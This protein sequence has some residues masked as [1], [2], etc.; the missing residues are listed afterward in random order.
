MKIAFMIGNGFDLN[1]G[2]NTGFPAFLKFYLNEQSTSSVVD[3]FKKEINADLKTWANLEKKLGEY[4]ANID[5]EQDA[6]A[7]Y[8]DITSQLEVFIHSADISYE[9]PSDQWMEIIGELVSP[10]FVLPEVDGNQVG[11]YCN[12][13]DYWEVDLISFNYTNYA[14]F[15]FGLAINS[16]VTCSF[17]NVN[18]ATILRSIEHIH[19]KTHDGMVLGVNDASQI[20]N[21]ELNKLGKI[22]K[23]FVKSENNR[24]YRRTH[25]DRCRSIIDNADMFCLYGL[26]LG[27]TDKI[28]WERIGTRLVNNSR[29]TCIIF[30]YDDKLNLYGNNG[31]D[32]DDY[33]EEMKESFINLSS[34]NQYR[35]KV[36]DRIFVC[37]TKAIFPKEKLLKLLPSKEL[38]I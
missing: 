13:G 23:R 28:W 27:E 16:Q 21:N 29:A 6:I 34:I 19:G 17:G 5:N 36:W 1:L 35:E 18:I 8:R 3:D 11:S 12:I 15:L 10:R 22:L 26:S 33:V 30:L 25:P 32:Y 24:T 4:L 7:I 20:H 37:T 2:L 38:E 31:P 14:D 9:S